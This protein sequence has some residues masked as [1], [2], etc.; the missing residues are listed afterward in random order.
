[1]YAAPD[2][3]YQPTI[4]AATQLFKSLSDT[5]RLVLYLDLHAH[6]SKRGCFVFG[7]AWDDDLSQID[8]LLFPKVM[9][10]NSAHFDFSGCDFTSRSMYAK[11][12]IEGSAK[13]G[14]GRVALATYGG[15]AQCYTVEASY[16]MGSCFN[17]IVTVEAD[18]AHDDVGAA[19]CHIGCSR[20]T[21][22]VGSFGYSTR[23]AGSCPQS[24]DR[25]SLA[26]YYDL[27]R[28]LAVT[29]LDVHGRNPLSRLPL[30]PVG[31]VAG[32][33]QLLERQLRELRQAQE[34]LDRSVRHKS[35]A[36]HNKAMERVGV[37]MKNFPAVNA[38]NCSSKH[39]LSK[40]RDRDEP[41][42][43]FAT[44]EPLRLL[45]NPR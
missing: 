42:E 32:V 7:N 30:L 38:Y 19:S 16:S 6:A 45:A 2:P 25:Y 20:P 3:K 44:I 10:M 17:N 12:K 34:R 39:R 11:N 28:A 13:N 33:R 41:D 22:R 21:G 14:T 1:M 4:Y 37:L 18:A 43:A 31:S 40:G 23:P 5:G 36:E 24:S 29:L 26:T 8:A 35:I 27:G 9:A 15:L